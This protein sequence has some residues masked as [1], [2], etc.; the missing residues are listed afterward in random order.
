M[1]IEITWDNLIF[2]ILT[3]NDIYL[4]AYQSRDMYCSFYRRII[5][6]YIYV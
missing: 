2:F 1:T 3:K 4:D 5:E 6:K